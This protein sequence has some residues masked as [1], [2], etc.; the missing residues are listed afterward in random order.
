MK[1]IKNLMKAEQWQEEGTV[2]NALLSNLNELEYYKQPYPKSLANDFGTD[3]LYSMIQDA[4]YE[5]QDALRT[6]M[7]ISLSKSV[8]P[9]NSLI[10]NSEL[11]TQATDYS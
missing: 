3:V 8:M 11:S 1:R 6:Y 9:S 4:K 10:S 5:L 7:N 2:Q